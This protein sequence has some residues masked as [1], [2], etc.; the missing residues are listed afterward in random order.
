MSVNY[1]SG[2]H[3][4]CHQHHPKKI[5]IASHKI[6][7]DDLIIVSPIENSNKLNT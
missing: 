1:H 5:S 2:F 4:R 7:P 3:P 6:I